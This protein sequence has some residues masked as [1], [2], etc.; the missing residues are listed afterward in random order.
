MSW[1]TLNE[2]CAGLGSVLFVFFLTLNVFEKTENS[3]NISPPPWRVT[4]CS[5]IMG[6]W[7]SVNVWEK[8]EIACRTAACQA[9]VSVMMRDEEGDGIQTKKSSKSKA[10]TPYRESTADTCHV[11]GDVTVP[12]LKKSWF[13]GA[14]P[15]WNLGP[16][17]AGNSVFQCFE[18]HKW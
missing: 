3:W 5:S 6:S 15:R 13:P 17:W 8:C 16:H 14:V 7:P 18:E 1:N 11:E 12:M 10:D 9:E 4:D 2:E